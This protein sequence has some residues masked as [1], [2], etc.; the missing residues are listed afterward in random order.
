MAETLRGARSGG[1]MAQDTGEIIDIQELYR[2]RGEKVLEAARAEKPDEGGQLVEFK[3]EGKEKR[4]LIDDKVDRFG[5][6]AYSKKTLENLREKGV[7]QDPAEIETAEQIEAARAASAAERKEKILEVLNGRSPE[8][9]IQ[10]MQGDIGKWE[11]EIAEIEA[12]PASEGGRME[13]AHDQQMVKEMQSRIALIESITPE[14]RA[15]LDRELGT[16][17]VVETYEDGTT[18]V[19][20]AMPVTTAMADE[21]FA[22]EVAKTEGPIEPG[23]EPVVGAASGELDMNSPLNTDEWRIRRQAVDILKNT[24]GMPKDLLASVE[25]ALRDAEEATVREARR[26]EGF[27]ETAPE[28]IAAGPQAED[29]EPVT[30]EQVR[31][32]NNRGEEKAER[33]DRAELQAQVQEKMKKRP[34]LKHRIRRVAATMLLT[35]ST[36]S[37]VFASNKMTVEA[38][39]ANQSGGGMRV[40]TTSEVGGTIEA[41]AQKGVGKLNKGA[42]TVQ[43]ETLGQMAD[44]TTNKVMELVGNLDTDERYEA[45]NGTR[46]RYDDFDSAEKHGKHGF[47][48]DKSEFWGD[49]DGTRQSILEINRAQPEVLAATVSGYPSILTEAGLDANMTARELDDLLSNQDGGGELQ[50]RL[51]QLL[52]EKL[53]D[54][55]TK[56]EFYQE[57]GQEYSYYIKN[58]LGD[59]ELSTPENL[60][61]GRSWMQRNGEKQVKI[62]IPIYN[63]IGAIDRYEWIDLNSECS[64]QRNDEEV[65][66]FVEQKA[67]EEYIEQVAEQAIQR[68]E[69]EQVAEQETQPDEEQP[70]EEKETEEETEDE[71]EED[72]EDEEDEEETKDEEE[73]EEDEDEE[74][75]QKSLENEERLMQGEGTS[76]EVTK[77]EDVTK[78]QE[79]TAQH[80]NT[81]D[82]QEVKLENAQNDVN[83]SIEDQEAAAAAQAAAEA[84][85][86]TENISDEAFDDF[87][88]SFENRVKERQAAEAAAAAANAAADSEG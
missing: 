2:R 53:S 8:M 19:R 24:A 59:G 77:T 73:D 72:E 69:E 44:A 25:R 45:E 32:D 48:T 61:L 11:A 43:A 3:H 18:T 56:F 84:N 86:V 35:L 78:I 83:A 9:A 6:P 49:V 76:A 51:Y 67:Q 15:E 7:E 30:Q 37:A 21:D 12:E 27:L 5:N 79:E 1:E 10:E 71:E 74:V 82:N 40:E 22:A 29:V 47:G 64:W 46:Y 13:I 50:E 58:T 4:V 38:A 80:E 55:N 31:T 57:Y 33:V 87:N 34:S 14:E 88:D 62:G 60:E 65:R 39:H 16:D 28:E 66:Q 54:A 41:S 23:E 70:V 85:K 81:E 20:E 63:E 75:K 26:A 36:A 17:V 68:A 42:G 52:E